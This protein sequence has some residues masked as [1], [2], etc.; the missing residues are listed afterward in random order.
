M[1]LWGLSKSAGDVKVNL[2][3]RIL[4]IPESIKIIRQAVKDLLYGKITNK[5]WE[6]HDTGI[7]KSYIEVPRGELYHSYGIEDG[8]KKFY[9]QER[10]S[11]TNVNTM[12][13]AYIGTHITDAQLAIF[14]CDHALHALTVQF[15]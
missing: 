14:Q 7:I 13:F 4:E 6:M 3:M 5:N 1:I 8:S 15:K 10:P 9:C 2:L 11:I 12:E